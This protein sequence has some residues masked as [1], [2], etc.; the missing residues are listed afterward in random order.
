MGI[1]LVIRGVSTFLLAGGGLKLDKG[2]LHLELG[3]RE[4]CA[5]ENFDFQRLSPAI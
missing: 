1:T 4:A 3:V 2:I 5:E